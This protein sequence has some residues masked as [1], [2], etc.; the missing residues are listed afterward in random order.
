[1]KVMMLPGFPVENPS[2]DWPTKPGR[3]DTIPPKM[4]TDTPLPMP[5]SVISSPIQTRNTVPAVMENSMARVGS[6]C[7]PERPMFCSTP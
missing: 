3:P 6:N 5:F 2:I 7:G 4:M 1:M